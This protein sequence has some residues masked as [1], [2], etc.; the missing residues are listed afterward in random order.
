[1]Q[2]ATAER[3]LDLYQ[4]FVDG[5]GIGAP[6]EVSLE[7]LADTLYCSTRNVKLVL[8]KMEEDG[9]IDW[10]PGRGRGNR[11]R[12][13]FRT[14]RD[15]LLLDVAKKM[16]LR[17]DYKQAFEMIHAYGEGTNV[18]E[19][20]TEWLDLHF[21]YRTETPDGKRQVDTLRLP[22]HTPIH[23]LDPAEVYSAFDGHLV[24]QLFDRLVQYDAASCRVMP[25]LAHAWEKN[26]DATVWQFH[27]R[28]GVRFHHGREL[29]ADDVIFTLDR[30]REGKS[31]SWVL[32]TLVKAEALGSRT[33]RI[34]LNKP[35]RIFH[36]FMCSAAVSILPR[37][38]VEQDEARFWRCP[39]GTGPFMATEW[40]MDR[41]VMAAHTDYFMGRAHVDGVVIAFMPEEHGGCSQR[42][43]EKL[44]SD[45]EVSE[46]SPEEEWQTVETLWQGCTLL[47]WNLMKEGPQRSM[48]FRRAIDALIDRNA[49]IR[50]LGDDRMY[51]ARGFR[52]DESMPNWN[53]ESE[54]ERALA[55][56][57]EAGYDGTPVTL[58]ARGVHVEDAEWIGKQCAKYG[59]N[60][61]V[62]RIDKSTA[63]KHDFSDADAILYGIKFAED[64]VC[65]I[66]TYEQ[67]GSY[68]KENL[69]PELQRWAREMIDLALDA[70]N[71]DERRVF[72]ERIERRLRE[73]AHVMFLIHKKVNTSFQP[74]IRGV[75]MGPLGWIDFKNVWVQSA[76]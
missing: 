4:R 34:E 50:D 64:D 72:L 73:E 61:R 22:V 16:A 76:D 17:G 3:Y 21:G 66:E 53:D 12:L 7:E 43:W 19:R 13:V 46:T 40:T 5:S 42:S 26:G 20:F 68:L 59:V 47:T 41:F 25:A 30:L 57:R 11:S 69:D 63:E 44:V 18:K 37:D 15:S 39:V 58:F 67:A 9:W 54:P 23:T 55:L 1:M 31:H 38:L 33:V 10:L 29:T 56:L 74:G 62:R 8:R 35:N 2:T 70:P 52:P 51:P 65:E 24:R 27:L 28:K 6:V 36:R 14:D 48:A 60:I 32:R 45:H 71:A 75:T 49:M